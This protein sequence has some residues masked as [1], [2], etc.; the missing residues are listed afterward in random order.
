MEFWSV[1]KEVPGVIIF[2]RPPTAHPECAENSHLV[3]N[4]A[5]DVNVVLGKEVLN[6]DNSSA[7]TPSVSP[8]Y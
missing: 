8:L 4:D 3:A 1:S 6:R 2:V 7:G 5:N